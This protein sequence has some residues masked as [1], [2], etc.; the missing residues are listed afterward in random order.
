MTNA[1]TAAVDCAGKVGVPALDPEL[2]LLHV[3][4]GKRKEQSHS[5]PASASSN[6]KLAISPL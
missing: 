4:R 3:N 6:F 2:L 5:S 1:Q